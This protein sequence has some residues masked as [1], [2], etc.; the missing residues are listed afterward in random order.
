[1]ILL[2]SENQPTALGPHCWR[3]RSLFRTWLEDGPLLFFPFW[4]PFHSSGLI[5]SSS[6]LSVRVQQWPCSDTHPVS[7]HC[8]APYSALAFHWSLVG[9]ACVLQVSLSLQ[10]LALDMLSGLTGISDLLS[11]HPFLISPS[12][13]L[14]TEGEHL[15]VVDIQSIYLYWNFEISNI[16]LKEVSCNLEIT[17]MELFCFDIICHKKSIFYCKWL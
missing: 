5:P 7:P 6:C 10:A 2:E 3:Q 13:S 15:K 17:V 16:Y 12:L 14:P 11:S 1:M 8:A 4:M 9:S